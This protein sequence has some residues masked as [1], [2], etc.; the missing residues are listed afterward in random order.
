MPEKRP[1]VQKEQS[2]KQGLAEDTGQFPTHWKFTKQCFAFGKISSGDVLMLG[3][4]QGNTFL[5]GR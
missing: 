5:G 1:D 2:E 4:Q 3:R